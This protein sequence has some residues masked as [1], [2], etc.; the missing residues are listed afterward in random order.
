[1]PVKPML[2]KP[3]YARCNESNK[4]TSYE[5]KEV[6]YQ[7]RIEVRANNE[8]VLTGK[9]TIIIHPAES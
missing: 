4:T 8:G 1:M 7:W 3:E 6:P 2:W 5:P 9:S